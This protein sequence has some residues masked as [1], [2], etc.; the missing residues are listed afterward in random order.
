MLIAFPA[1]GSLYYAKDLEKVAG[2]PV[3]PLEDER[4][5]VGPDTR[6]L[7]WFG[8]R[9]HVTARR[10][11]RTTSATLCL[12]YYSLKRTNNYRRKCRGCAHKRGRQETSLSRAVQSTAVAVLAHEEGRLPAPGAAA[13]GS[14]RKPG[15]LSPHHVVTHPQEPR[16][17]PHPPSRPP[18]EQYN[19][20][21]VARL[22]WLARQ[23]KPD[24][25]ATYLDPALISPC[26]YTP[27][28]TELQ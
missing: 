22:G 20:S 10:R 5:C 13:V 8:R 4:F 14:Y 7:L 3:T 2:R 28:A 18:A 24:R 11:S 9:S 1:G 19:R 25:L 15:T 16:S 17:F 26:W 27:T 6:L 23:S 21:Q 12:F